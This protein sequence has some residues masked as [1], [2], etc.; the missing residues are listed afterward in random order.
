MTDTKP[1]LARLSEFQD[2][3]AHYQV[4]AHAQ[5]VLDSTKL[6]VMVGL[7][8]GG[9]NTII[10]RLADTG[11]YE[12]IISDTTRQPKVRDGVLEQHGVQY[13][14]R[15]EEDFLTDLRSGEFL[16]AEIIHKQQVSGT[17]IRELAR[18]GSTG[19][20]AIHDFEFGGAD[21]IAHT[22]P[23]AY[24]IGLLPPSYSEWR[25]RLTDRESS[26]SEAEL[27]NRTHTAQIVLTH[28]L[29]KP[30]FKLV[31]NDSIDQCVADIRQIVEHNV[32]DDAK[33]SHAE[34]VAQRILQEIKDSH[35]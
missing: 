34:A 30:Y 20:I 27:E 23:D 8:G 19:K 24:V 13:F 10:N 35:K 15:T 26:I 33:S 14:F 28:M 32:Y 5:H 21:I 2:I 1:K 4:S 12:F 22:K 25:R 16:E 18:A 17:S 6:V 3:L 7:A 29:E 9:R 31:V 11:E